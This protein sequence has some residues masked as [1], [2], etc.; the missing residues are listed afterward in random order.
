MLIKTVLPDR[1]GLLSYCDAQEL[2][3]TLLD[4]RDGIRNTPLCSFY[5]K[6]GAS[7]RNF[8]RDTQCLFL[9]RSGRYIV[10]GNRPFLW[11]AF[12]EWVC[13]HIP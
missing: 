10:A 4:T 3:R 13:K 7:A 8:I 11:E 2:T 5:Y 6:E 9:L 1:P 12:G